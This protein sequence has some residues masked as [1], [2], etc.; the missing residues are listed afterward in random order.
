MVFIDASTYIWVDPDDGDTVW[1]L[2]RDTRDPGA[3]QV[4]IY[5]SRQDGFRPTS[6][7]ISGASD[8][9]R[10]GNNPVDDPCSHGGGYGYG[11][12]GSSGGGYGGGGDDG[13]GYGGG[14]GGGH[15][16]GGGGD[17]DC[18]DSDSGDELDTWGYR[19]HSYRDVPT[20]CG[21]YDDSDFSSDEM[22]CG[23]GGG[24]TSALGAVADYGYGY[25][26][27]GYGGGDDCDDNNGGG[28]YGYGGGGGG[29][30][31]GSGYGYGNGYGGY[32]YGAAEDDCV[33]SAYSYALDLYSDGC[34]DYWAHPSWCGP[35][36]VACDGY[37]LV[38]K[39]SDPDAPRH[40]YTGAA[41][42]TTS[43]VLAVTS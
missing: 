29:G 13:S 4:L 10:G 20:W 15:G 11:G 43:H 3:A 21:G 35:R 26:G 40:L 24:T 36:L 42:T 28:A 16:G 2:N 1:K 9:D 34:E 6:C 23:C 12:Y 5:T 7:S 18:V 27:Y 33:D 17:D 39:T 38:V 37:F 25:G 32:A 41:S 14:Y 19:C 30:A 22:C 31:Y 8:D